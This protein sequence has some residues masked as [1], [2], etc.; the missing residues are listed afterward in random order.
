M[1]TI[2]F[3]TS[4]QE[5]SFPD[6][7]EVNLLRIALRNDVAIPFKCASGNCG[8]DRVRVVE[9]LDQCV[10]ARR[11]ERER[12]GELIDEGYRLSCQTY[13]KGDVVVAWDPDQTALGASGRAYERLKQVWL[14]KDD[15]A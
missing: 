13:V 4:N 3:E 7:E 8:T 1:P 2:R 10:P 5:V 15:G 11:R 14:A 9:G 12:L 6:G